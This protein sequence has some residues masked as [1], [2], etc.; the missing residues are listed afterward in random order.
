MGLV[1]GTR[2]GIYEIVALL[3]SG[4][5]GEVYR[6][7]DTRL[8]REVALKVLPATFTNDPDRVARFRREA[9]LLASLNHAHIAQIHGL[10]EADGTQFIVLELVEGESLDRR[11]ARGPVPLNQALGIARQMAEALEAA[12]EKGII[13]RDLKPANV[14][15][16][17]DGQVKVLDFG[18]AK[19][20]EAAPAPA[21]TQSPTLSIMGT[22]AGVILGTAAY[23]SPEQARGLAA[24]HRSDIFSFGV[25][26]FEMLTGRQ[27]FH[28]ETTPDILASV[29]VREA[30]LSALP[31][32]LTPRLPEL[33]RRCLDKNPKRRW[34]AIGDVGVEL[35]T[36]ATAPKAA[37]T[38]LPAAVATPLWTFAAVALVTA[39]TV[40]SLAGFVVWTATRAP[41]PPVVRFSLAL[42]ADQH[43]TNPGRR[44]LAVSPDARQI[45][46]VANGEL[47][48]KRL[49]EAEASPVK[50]TEPNAKSLEGSP[51]TGITNPVFSPDSSFVAYY[52]VAERAIKKVATA[53][54]T[55][56]TICAAVNPLG[57]TW[58]PSGIIFSQQDIGIM[59]VS[60]DGGQ[61]ELLVAV[62]GEL[63]HDPQLL[64]GGKSLLL[65]VSTNTGLRPRITLQ[66]LASGE[67]RSL[68]EDG[69]DA[70]YLPTGHLLFFRDGVLFAA[71]FD[72]RRE[73]VTDGAVPIVEGVRRNLGGAGGAA[74]FAVSDTGALVYVPGS[75][76]S[77]SQ[78]VLRRIDRTGAQEALS[79]PS[80]AYSSPRISP[81]G[82]WLAVGTDEGSDASIWLYDLSGET[83][84]RRLTLN[85]RNRF[86]VWA[87]DS[88]RVTFQ[89]DRDGD[90]GIF[91][92]RIDGGSAERLTKPEPGASH[93]PESWAPDGKTLL[94]DVARDDGFALHAYSRPERQTRPLGVQSMFMS[95]PVFSPDGQWV[96]YYHR[97]PG[98]I[99]GSLMVV[100]FSSPLTTH[101]VYKGGGIHPFWSRRQR[102]LQLFYR[103]PNRLESVDVTFGQAIAFGKVTEYRWRQLPGDSPEVPR[104]MEPMP[105]GE[106]FIAVDQPVS[107]D[108]RA[109]GGETIQVVLNWFEELKARVATRGH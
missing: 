59:R 100:S 43:F 55:P 16:T 66:S 24:D 106:H 63:A 75:A 41:A 65:T 20:L 94:F 60:P 89:S 61:P 62:K 32:G 64:P 97:P 6:A 15:L 49:S 102:Q 99:T 96:A 26:L 105:D 103:L 21:V 76:F 48:I 42:L 28:G 39:V 108:S 109:P 88:T 95:S 104:L 84:M 30:D 19:A 85:G 44:M 45:A 56:T 10:D 57:M 58:G 71:P 50:G 70:R 14:A 68:I 72:A 93:I 7:K 86:P 69:T 77:V 78:R 18:L 73:V 40:G 90:A 87:A 17:R 35:E 5:M 51:D 53:G 9:Q 11:I 23:M 29:L 1:E 4:G 80:G 46:F 74:Q 47:F 22:E 36:I 37:P 91:W 82:R 67:R 27:A 13:H 98:S 2:F 8:G 92:Q 52:R 79:V 101:E 12:H 34:Q 31:A 33:L 81:D 25:V 83:K 54:G 3:G 107:D 38:Q